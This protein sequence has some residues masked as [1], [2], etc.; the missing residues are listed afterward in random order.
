MPGKLS[1]FDPDVRFVIH[2]SL[3]QSLECLYAQEFGRA[4]RDGEESTSCIFFRFEDRT[5]HM[6]MIYS[7]PESE[8]RDLKRR[9]LN[10]VIKYCIIHTQMQKASIGPLFF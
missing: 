2:L 8:H 1:F 5:R 3:P 4:G 10:E 7:L 6:H 9:K